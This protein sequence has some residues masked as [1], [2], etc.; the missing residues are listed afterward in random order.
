M[1]AQSGDR[2]VRREPSGRIKHQPTALATVAIEAQR[3]FIS[4]T[5]GQQLLLMVVNLISRQFSVVGKIE[6]N[7][8]DTELE[9]NISWPGVTSKRLRAAAEEMA[10]FVGGPEIVT[11]TNGH[12]GN[13]QV[14]VL[15][16][17]LNPVDY[18]VPAVA[19]VAD[20]WRIAVST[21]RSVPLVT[22]ASS[23]PIGPFLTAS[24]AAWYVFDVL[25]G[26]ARSIDVCMSAWNYSHGPW[27]SLEVGIDPCGI[28]LPDAYLIGAGAVGAAVVRTL[29]STP[30]LCI[31]IVAIDSQVQSNTDR[32]RLISGG[33]DT[34]GKSKV[35]LVEAEI[36]P[37]F[38]IYPF[39]GRWPDD[40]VTSEGRD[41][42]QD[43]RKF[44]VDYKFEW[45][46]SCVDRNR[47][48]SAIA[49]YL[50]RRVIGGSTDGLVA[51]AVRYSMIG[52]CECLKCNHPTPS[53]E[54]LEDLT[55]LLSD[56]SVRQEWLSTHGADQR[57]AA[58]IAEYL[59]APECGEL[60]E[61]ELVRLGREGEV[62]WSVGFVSVAAGVLQA[63]LFIREALFEDGIVDSKKSEVRLIF[64][65]TEFVESQALRRESCEVCG[66][67][68]ALKTWKQL[69]STTLD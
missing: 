16:G 45:I 37:G 52:N 12:S 28:V 50:P 56:P 51:Q 62:D 67:S 18:G 6:L 44:E 42:P 27:D 21:L 17:S 69:W 31:R 3:D 22:Q 41:I 64:H 8:P 55:S 29:T 63:S 19:A 40:Y 7:F 2:H 24:I 11:V 39:Q 9:D 15:I 59:N 65:R 4:T 1:I 35:E 54:T 47:D 43:F 58:A 23:N 49:N 68:V 34:V 14:A 60:G 33:Y 36:R 13:S 66:D 61:A 48:R 32:N 20:G 30:H 46:L 25:C 53:S 26:E 10:H 5:A 38:E 57:T